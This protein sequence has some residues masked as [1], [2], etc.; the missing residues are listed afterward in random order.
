MCELC[1]AFDAADRVDAHSLAR[2][3]AKGVENG[4]WQER[5]AKNNGGSNTNGSV[6]KVDKNLD[7]KVIEKI[8][9]ATGAVVLPVLRWDKES[10]GPSDPARGSGDE[11]DDFSSSG[12]EVLSR[13]FLL[14]LILGSVT[15]LAMVA[16]LVWMCVKAA[17]EE[18][19]QLELLRDK[20]SRPESRIEVKG[21]GTGGETA[22]F[23]TILT[24][25]NN[26]DGNTFTAHVLH[27]SPFPRC[28]R[29]SPRHL[30]NPAPWRVA[31]TIE[32][33]KSEHLF[34]GENLWNT[35]PIGGHLSTLTQDNIWTS[36]PIVF[37]LTGMKT[38]KI[39]PGLK[40]S[41]YETGV[42]EGRHRGCTSRVRS[43]L[44]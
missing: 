3:I 43:G 12:E 31:A 17:K 19:S 33:P 22:L 20:Q 9:K 41:Q 39:T 15:L 24:A 7:D 35:T 18:G 29:T 13:R 11:D 26:G 42:Y 1:L 30:R 23:S 40:F 14:F 32:N 4:W 37:V 16:G 21:G 38:S 28:A 25:F 44:V 10:L 6:R 2:W 36:L 27:A 5:I 8:G 34:S